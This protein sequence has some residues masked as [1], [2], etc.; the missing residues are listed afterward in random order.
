[1]H[2]IV[3]WPL[4]ASRSEIVFYDLLPAAHFGTENFEERAKVYSDYWRVVLEEDRSMIESLQR[5][6]SSAR[7]KPGPLSS[8]EHGV[9]RLL[10]SY[11]ERNFTEQDP[12]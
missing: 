8:L 7:F 6:M 10:Q 12:A 4:T 11:V 2:V 5:A 1:V 3:A 9:H